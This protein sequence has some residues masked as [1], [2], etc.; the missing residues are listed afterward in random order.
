[1]DFDY[2]YTFQKGN[3]WIKTDNVFNLSNE[4]LSRVET[5]KR[6]RQM[7]QRREIEVDSSEFI[8]SDILPQLKGKEMQKIKKTVN[9]EF[10]GTR[11][12]IWGFEIAFISICY[13]ICMC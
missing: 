6:S 11:N 1:M 2:S 3:Q 10:K 8:P 13:K 4:I 5:T 7:L 12:C 9:I